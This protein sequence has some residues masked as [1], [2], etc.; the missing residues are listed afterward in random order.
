MLEYDAGISF[1]DVTV[2][3]YLND[4][5]KERNKL[6][7][8]KLDVCKTQEYILFYD[9]MKQLE[10][11]KCPAD[12]SEHTDEFKTSIEQWNNIRKDIHKFG[13]QIDN[14][15]RKLRDES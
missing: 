5:V 1:D 15:Q 2:E 8:K 14:V 11:R 4:I 12:C 9:N 3:Q 13:N 10:E 6:A 7:H